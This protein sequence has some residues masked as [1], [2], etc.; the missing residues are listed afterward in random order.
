MNKTTLL[1]TTLLITIAFNVKAKVPE[2]IFDNIKRSSVKQIKTTPVPGIYQVKTGDTYLYISEDG[3]YAFTTMFDLKNKVSITERE[4]QRD[5][6]KMVQSI[7]DKDL[8]V[9]EQEGELKEEILIFTDTS[10]PYCK[11]LHAEVPYLLKKGIR[12]KYAAFPRG[13]LNGPGFAELNKV[14]CSKDRAAALDIAKALRPTGAKLTPIKGCDASKEIIATY[15]LGNKLGVLGTPA[16][17]TSKGVKIEGYMPAE[18]L[19]LR[20][21]I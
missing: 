18:R 9:Y 16:I 6:I 2:H 15:N 1:I 8:I 7:K 3:K 13:G 12:V 5:N 20:M 19:I 14:F 17:F 21:G 4:L 11:K 10:C